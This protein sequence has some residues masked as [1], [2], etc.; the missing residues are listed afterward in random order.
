[1]A[2]LKRKFPTLKQKLEQKAQ[3][4]NELQK[5]KEEIEKEEG[6]KKQKII[7]NKK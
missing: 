3:L 6:E 5:T 7:K 2:P 1:M 4:E